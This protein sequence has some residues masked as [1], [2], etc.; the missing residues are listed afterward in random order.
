MWERKNPSRDDFHQRFSEHCLFDLAVVRRISTAL[1]L[2][3]VP[4]V[5]ASW[6]GDIRDTGLLRTSMTMRQIT[7]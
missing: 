5:A 1:T 2:I 6:R 7:R 4:V 3:I